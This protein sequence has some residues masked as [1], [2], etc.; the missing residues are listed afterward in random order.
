MLPDLDMR[1]PFVKHRGPTHTV[2][3][4]LGIGVVV[5]L[6]GFLLGSSDGLLAALGLGTYGVVV[7]GL[8]VGA[9]LLADALTPMGIRPL[10]PV[11]DREYCLAVTRAANPL[12][13]YGLLALGVVVASVGFLAGSAIAGA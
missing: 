9:H 12:A 2:W 5:G 13:N 8:A 6:L 10:E 1:V 11:D 7:G 4:A 3:F